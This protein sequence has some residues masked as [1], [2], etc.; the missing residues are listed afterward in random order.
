M[1]VHDVEVELTNSM[2]QELSNVFYRNCLFCNKTVRMS[3]QNLDVSLKLVRKGYFCAFCVR[4][5]FHHKLRQN[6]LIFSFRGVIG[7][8]Y[9]DLYRFERKFWHSQIKDLIDNHSF[10]GLQNPVLHY[11]PSSYLWFAD[12]NRIGNGDKKISITDT[13]LSIR[14]ILDVFNLPNNHN[15]KLWDR[16]N[17]AIWLFYTQRKRPKDKRALIPTLSGICGHHHAD[18]FWDT[19]RS[20]SPEDLVVK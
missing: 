1:K 16:F 18:C 14:S 17:Q 13:T 8:Y 15:Q 6:V 3:S 11:D 20:F 5:N 2:T 7:Y 4:N 10:V 12:F 19:T 9:W